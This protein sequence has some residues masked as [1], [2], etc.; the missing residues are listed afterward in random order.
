MKAPR[1]IAVALVVVLASATTGPAALGDE[2]AD[3]AAGVAASAWEAAKAA[4][5]G[6]WTAAGSLL[7][8]PDPF[9]YLP[10]QM[11]NRDR[12]FLA[13]MEAAGYRLAA[14]DTGEGLFGRVRYRFRQQRALSPGDLERIRRGLAEHRARHSGAVASA[15]R[16]ALRGLL[17]VGAATGFRVAAVDVDLRPWPKVSFR[18]TPRDPIAA[19]LQ[20]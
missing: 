9:E 14:I 16:R 7:A 19:P 20:E 10:E 1:R 11:P 18:L 15:E 17:A 4:T 6:L 3:G 2:I 12:R 13:L 8:S 5:G